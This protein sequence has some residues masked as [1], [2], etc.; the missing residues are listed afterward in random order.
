MIKIKKC[1]I[2]GNSK[3]E[4]IE[5]I[6]GI[7]NFSVY[8]CL[9]CELFFQ[10]PIPCKKDLENFYDS[11]YKKECNFS[12]TE[13]SFQNFNNMQEENRVKKI[14]KFIRKGKLLDVGASTGFFVSV[15][16]KRGWKVMGVEYSKEAVRIAKEKF[17]IFLVN[18]EI[19]SNKIPNN[20]FDVV[21]MHSVLEHLPD[22]EETVKE[23]NKKL[24][25]RGYF[26]FNVPN[27][28]S[29]EYSFYKM[30]KRKFPGF[31]FEHLYYFNP[32]N[33]ELLM[34]RNGF[35]IKKMTSRHFSRYN[36]PLRPLIGLA[37]F[38]PKLFLEYSDI[39]GI[40]K[41]GNIIYVYA[42]KVK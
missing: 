39:G 24:K 18:G 17:G 41:K 32:D 42:Q 7:F 37:T 29:F 34:E 1:P 2:C 14:E 31:I 19:T 22:L 13:K 28:K 8:K 5:K 40:L 9:N 26:V 16:K 4:S 27:V 15:A 38:M 23:V 20:Y 30:L 10:N 6:K 36:L 3:F 33:I 12:L 11:V 21:T 35:S 25:K